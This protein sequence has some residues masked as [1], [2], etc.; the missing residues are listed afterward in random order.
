MKLVEQINQS[1]FK[2]EYFEPAVNYYNYSWL[3][4]F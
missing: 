3:F 2:N 1:K 4:N